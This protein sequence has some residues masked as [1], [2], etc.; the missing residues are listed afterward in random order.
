MSSVVG[1]TTPQFSRGGLI[2]LLRDNAA[3]SSRGSQPPP[4][5]DPDCSAFRNR[6][7][8][9][10]STAR[11][12]VSP[13]RRR[14]TIDCMASSTWISPASIPADQTP[15]ASSTSAPMGRSCDGNRRATGSDDP[16]MN[17]KSISRDVSTISFAHS[18][19]HDRCL[20]LKTGAVRPLCRYTSTIC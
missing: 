13:P 16:A 9:R 4:S 5:Q 19:F 7:P 8:R 15:M 20:S 2:V 17:P 10:A 14:S 1:K 6:S 18:Q 12:P 11:M 3:S